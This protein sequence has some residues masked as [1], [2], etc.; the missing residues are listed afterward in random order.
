M[1]WQ[2]VFTGKFLL[3]SAAWNRGFNWLVVIAAANVAI[4][5]FYYL[6]LVRYAYTKQSPEASK[7]AYAG[8]G[9]TSIKHLSGGLFLAGLV[10]LFGILPELV[11]RLLMP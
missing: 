10:V 6:N 5:L 7:M 3:L 9:G 4:G 8:E 1:R 2:P 11:L